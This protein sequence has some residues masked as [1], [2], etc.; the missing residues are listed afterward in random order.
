MSIDR[1]TWDLMRVNADLSYLILLLDCGV[2]RVE[3]HRLY[4]HELGM[5]P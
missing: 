4:N 1:E 3:L 5:R 2:R